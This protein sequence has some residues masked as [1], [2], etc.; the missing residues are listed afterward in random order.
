[1][2]AYKMPGLARRALV[3]ILIMLS[4]VRKHRPSINQKNQSDN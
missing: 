4:C 3:I 1:M 2:K